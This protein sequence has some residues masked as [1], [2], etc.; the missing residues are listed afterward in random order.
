[1]KFGYFDI[2]CDLTKT[3]PY[4]D[5]VEDYRRIADI[6][7]VS[8]FDA[9]WFGEHHFSVWGR[10]IT[11]N[12]VLLA[13]DL[14]ARTKRLRIGLGAVIITFWHPLRLAEDIAVLDHLSNGRLELGVGRG[15]YGLEAL[16][17]NPMADPN[18]PQQNFDI[19]AET[20]AIL[21]KAFAGSFAHKGAHYQFPTPGLHRR[22]GPHGGR[23]RTSSTPRPTSWSRSPWSPGR[24]SGRC[25]CGPWAP[26]IPPSNSPPRP[27]AA[28]SCGAP[29]WP[30]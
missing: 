18:N 22:Q 12:P 17:L 15:N 29:P 25:P 6:C 20:L 26:A 13:A 24:C 8:G 7:E 21:K 14:A 1:M 23:P 9:I 4:A 10:E 2:L 5:I 30:S 19:F 11:P 16:N 3:R 28:S 27:T